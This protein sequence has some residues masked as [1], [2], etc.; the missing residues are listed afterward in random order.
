MSIKTVLPTLFLGVIFN[1]YAQN[2]EVQIRVDSLS[3]QVY[4][5]T[6]KGGNIGIYIGETKVFMIDDQFDHLSA[7]IK[8]SIASLTDK[9]ISTL[10]NTHMHGDHSG[11]NANFNTKKVTLVAHDNVRKR[12]KK[13]QKEKLDKQEIPKEKYDKMLPEVTFSDNITFFDGDE[14]IMAFHVHNAHTDGDSMVYF[15][16]NN[17]L[18]MGDTYFSGRYPFIDLKS[19]G[20]IHGYINAIKKAL[21]LINDNTK[22]IP[23]HGRPSNK[24]EL[25][26]YVLLL[27]DI[28]KKIQYAINS[29]SSLE[30]VKA[31]TSLTQTYDARY[32]NGFISPEKIRETYYKSLT[33]LKK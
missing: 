13:N 28:L 22:I 17:V 16:K 31:N 8:K 18:H 12:I 6:G 19:G 25:Q 1:C 7:K 15:L 33:Q 27:E 5:L 9:P 32:G 2:N 29:G 21:L 20:S 30:E 10:F 3:P 11:G 26:N 4:M 24:A 23:G 14:T